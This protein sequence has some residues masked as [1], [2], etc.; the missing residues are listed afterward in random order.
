MTHSHTIADERGRTGF[1]WGEHFGAKT[2]AERFGDC[3]FL[4]LR[5]ELRTELYRVQ[6]FQRRHPGDDPLPPP[7]IIDAEPAAPLPAHVAGSVIWGG[8]IATRAEAR[9]LERAAEVPILMYHSVAESG[10][11][12][13]S[14]FRVSPAMFREHLRFLR[15][16][17]YHSIPLGEWASSIANG[18]PLPGRP[19]VI[20]FDDGYRDFITHAAPLLEAADFRA[21]VFVVAGKVGAAADWDTTSWPPLPLMGWDDLRDL[22]GRGFEIGSHTSSHADLRALSEED[23]LRDSQSARAILREQ[24][25]CDVDIMALP[26]GWT[27]ARIRI[28]LARAAFRA[29]VTTQDGRSSLYSDP[30]H[31]PRIEVTGNDDADSFARLL[32]AGRRAPDGEAFQPALD[33]DANVELVS[34]RERLRGAESEATSERDRAE[35]AEKA[36]RTER[37]RAEFAE[38]E[39]ALQR[40]L[41]E[42]AGRHALH[43]AGRADAAQEKLDQTLTRLEAIE[44]STTWRA[45]APFRSCFSTRPRLARLARR[46]LK[47]AWWTASLQLP[48]KVRERLRRRRAGPACDALPAGAPSV[49]SLTESLP[50]TEESPPIELPD[51]AA[52]QPPTFSTL[53]ASLLS[54][55]PMIVFSFNN[56][57]YL[58]SMIAQLRARNLS[59]ITVIDNASHAPGM[60]EYLSELAKETKVVRLSENIG[61]HYVFLCESA[62]RW[63]PDVFC[64]TDPDLS[65][66]PDLPGNFLEELA[67]LTERLK[68]GKAGF[69]LDISDRDAMRDD[70]FEING[71]R[72][73]IWEWEQQFWQQEI[74]KT[75][76]GD[77]IFRAPIDTTFALYNKRYFNREAFYDAVRVAGRFTCRHLPWYHDHG[78]PEDEAELYRATQKFSYYMTPGTQ[79]QPEIA[80]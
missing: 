42:E 40:M 25:G 49:E 64:L 73:K 24:L 6:L 59:N 78:M 1:D 50:T 32:K 30:L 65:F 34:L 76:G 7:E 37:A 11:P 71:G 35:I 79:K 28:A 61:P 53:G 80:S 2:I 77:P 17:G 68:V 63:L 48:E 10:P 57:A 69:A 8:A 12:E 38:T 4:A 62:Y 9:E 23:I 39:A 60:Q 67:E 20:T 51:A 16:H 47:L 66:G 56:T 55:I 54:G 29:A 31:L 43:E 58:R 70:M 18:K 52:V 15:R 19:V 41:A 22:R 46:S 72:Y 36:L 21:T 74:G 75:G 45:T 27:D 14:R 44:S 13:L 33:P 3:P 26:W 5:K